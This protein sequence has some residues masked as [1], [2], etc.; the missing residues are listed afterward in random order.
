MTYLTKRSIR[1]SELVGTSHP[2]VATAHGCD[3]MCSGFVFWYNSSRQGSSIA[4][5]PKAEIIEVQ[6]A[7]MTFFQGYQQGMSPWPLCLLA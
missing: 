2:E 3:T 5:K 4:I 1:A 6:G 7:I